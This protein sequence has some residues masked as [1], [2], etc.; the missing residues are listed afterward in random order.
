[1]L[2]TQVEAW[3]GQGTNA[4]TNIAL[5]DLTSEGLEYVSTTLTARWWGVG[6]KKVEI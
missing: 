2:L 5:F 6:C 3:A 1:M 4:L